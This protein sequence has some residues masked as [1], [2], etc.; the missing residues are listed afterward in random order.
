MSIQEKYKEVTSTQ[1]HIVAE[2]FLT[3][4]Q[5]KR[6]SEPSNDQHAIPITIKPIAALDCVLVGI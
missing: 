2:D 5:I 1:E 3:E 6:I 4:E